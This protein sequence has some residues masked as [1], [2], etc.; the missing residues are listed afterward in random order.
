MCS[1]SY[2]NF[3]A[4]LLVSSV[5]VCN[6]P[7]QFVLNQLY[8][9]HTLTSSYKTHM[10]EKATVSHLTKSASTCLRSKLKELT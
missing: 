10:S 6:C 3:G 2:W 1:I 8:V 5:P 9:V 7:D 4:T